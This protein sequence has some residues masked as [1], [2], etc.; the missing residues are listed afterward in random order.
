MTPD[1]QISLDYDRLRAHVERQWPTTLKPANRVHRHP[2]V[3][4]GSV[5]EG[6]LWDWDSFWASYALLGLVGPEHPDRDLLLAHVRGNID[7][8]LSYQLDDGYIPIMIQEKDGDE[9]YLNARH[10]EG[11]LMNQHKPFLAQH[12][13]LYLSQSDDLAW[14]RDRYDAVRAY[15]DCYD[16]VYFRPGPGLYVWADDVMIGMDNDPATFGRPPFSTAGLFLN[17][18]LVAELS[19]MAHLAG[20]LGR[21][22]D[23]EAFAQKRTALIGALNRECWDPRDRCYYSVDVDVRTRPF[24]WF[25]QGLGVFW[26]SLPIKIRTWMTFL[27]LWSGGPTADQAAAL[28]RV[29]Y[30]DP[31]AFDA[32][33]GIPSLAMDEKMYNLEPTINPSNWLGPVWLVVQYVVFRGLLDHGYR[34]QA[35]Q[36]CSKTLRLLA[37]DLERTGTLHEFYHPGTGEPIMN[38]GFLNWN[39]LALSMVRELRG[40]IAL[41][42]AWRKRM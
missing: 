33:F 10:K 15:L 37:R 17:A 34:E 28:A 12:L 11:K 9:P 14:A 13:C 4:P 20:L 40:E 21:G 6:N 36:L 2:Y 41:D 1:D 7:N 3:D 24:D 35:S 32:P 39:M 25:H 16:R 42:A 18:F 30:P 31:A 19:A 29:H 5:Y 27:P 22:A 26:H 8:F 23:A 38:G